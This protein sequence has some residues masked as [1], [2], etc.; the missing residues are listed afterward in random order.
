[1]VAPCSGIIMTTFMLS[2][3]VVVWLIILLCLVH[4]QAWLDWLKCSQEHLVSMVL[5]HIRGQDY[6]GVH[7]WSVSVLMQVPWTGYSYSPSRSTLLS[8][9]PHLYILPVWGLLFACVNL[10]Y[11][12]SLSIMKRLWDH[13]P[14]C[15]LKVT[16]GFLVNTKVSTWTLLNKARTK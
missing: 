1:M 16:N 15:P 13:G 10:V 3:I 4:A 7:Y 9:W 12:F 6:H 8:L 2:D 5:C 14:A 11:E